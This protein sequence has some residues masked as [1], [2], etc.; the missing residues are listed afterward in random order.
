MKIAKRPLKD[1]SVE[2]TCTFISKAKAKAEPSSSGKMLLGYSSGFK[3]LS[4]AEGDKINIVYGWNSGVAKPKAEAKAE[5]EAVE[6][7]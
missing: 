2:V 3:T 6:V 7:E 1:G 4:E 5:A